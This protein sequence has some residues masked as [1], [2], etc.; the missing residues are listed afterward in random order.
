LSA[1]RAFWRVIFK[2]HPN[3]SIAPLWIQHDRPGGFALQHHCKYS[4]LNYDSLPGRQ[5]PNRLPPHP[6]IRRPPRAQLA[7]FGVH[8]SHLACMRA[9]GVTATV[10]VQT[11]ARQRQRNALVSCEHING[12]VRCVA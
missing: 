9:Q 2:S 1:R 10:F 11:S 4:E 5:P 3:N 6:S 12:I 8:I 7:R